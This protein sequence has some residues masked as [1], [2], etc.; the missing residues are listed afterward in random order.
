ME[1]KTVKQIDLTPS[2]AL[3]IG[4]P[5]PFSNLGT[6]IPDL[7]QNNQIDALNA[8]YKQVYDREKLKLF[9]Y[10]N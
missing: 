7:F 5:I 8:N 4:I 6:I 9:T 2:L 3:L 10:F 1:Y